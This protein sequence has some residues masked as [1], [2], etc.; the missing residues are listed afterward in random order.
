MNRALKEA[1]RTLSPNKLNYESEA[2]R[3]LKKTLQIPEVDHEKWI[4]LPR[5]YSR[6]DNRF[7]LPIDSREFTDMTPIKYLGQFVIVSNKLKQQYRRIFLKN[8]PEEIEEEKPK[9]DD[10]D[11]ESPRN[12]SEKIKKPIKIDLEKKRTLPLPVFDKA[13]QEVLGFHGTIEKIQEIKEILNIEIEDEQNF[14][15][16]RLWCGIVAFAERFITKINR[17]SDPCNEVCF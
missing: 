3:N 14:I 10:L 15:D 2:V 7:E 6:A 1:Y 5:R 13:L 8:L 4:K 16:F 17:N 11:N 12:D 9:I